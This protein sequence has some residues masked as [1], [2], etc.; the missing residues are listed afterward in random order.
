MAITVT[1]AVEKGGVGKT[2]TCVNL[3]AA[4]AAAGKK[5]LAVDM[6]TQANCTYFLTG[7]KKRTEAYKNRG[8]AEMLRAYGLVEPGAF[9]HPTQIPGVDI[10][11]SNAASVTLPETLN[12]LAQNY[13][14]SKNRFLA[15]CLAKVSE[16][17][18][19]VL[20]DTPPNLEVMTASALLA[21]GTG[22]GE[23]GIPVLLDPVGVGASR[24]RRETA[25]KLLDAVRDFIRKV[26]SLFKGNKTAQSQA[27]A[28]AYGVSI[29][30]LEEAA[31]LWEEALKAT[32]EQTANKNAAHW[33]AFLWIWEFGRGK[34][35][36]FSRTVDGGAVSFV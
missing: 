20:I 28:N 25:G 32:S 10:I 27:A 8:V 4:M 29:D 16:G 26:K 15:Y 6:D 2:T 24:F 9:I 22:G 14:D 18:D 21:A 1:V 23:V 19:Y 12:T 7:N 13:A 30:T 36:L 34:S 31:R 17:Y 11:P 35:I 5:V 33:A 3:A